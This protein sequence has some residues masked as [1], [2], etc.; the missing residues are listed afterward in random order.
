MAAGFSLS[1]EAVWFRNI[2]Q[3]LSYFV[4]SR[5]DRSALQRV[6]SEEVESAA[7][8]GPGAV[9]ADCSNVGYGG[10]A[11]ADVGCVLKDHI[12]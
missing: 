4:V 8:H 2:L 7:L 12:I 1:K 5:C 11:N 6:A 9:G 3:G 10:D